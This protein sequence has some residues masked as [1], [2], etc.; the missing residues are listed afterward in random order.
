MY[1]NFNLTESEREEILN[2]HK[3]YGYKQLLNEQH[4]IDGEGPINTND[5][6]VEVVDEKNPHIVLVMNKMTGKFGVYDTNSKDWLKSLTSKGDSGLKSLVYSDNFK[7]SNFRTLG[8]GKMS[9]LLVNPD[10]DKF[11]VVQ[12]R[13]QR[14]EIP[15]EIPKGIFMN[16][17]EYESQYEVMNSLNESQVELLNTFK[18]FIK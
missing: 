1:K 2:G 18:R 7:H 5:Y 13:H 14:D 3:K 10:G 8:D 16:P 9:S 11:Y 17:M 15:N 4:K 12:M 6:K